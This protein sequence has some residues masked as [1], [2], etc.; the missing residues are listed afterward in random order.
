MSNNK[1]LLT[2]S[3]LVIVVLALLFVGVKSLTSETNSRTSTVRALNTSGLSD[4]LGSDYI[5]YSRYTDSQRNR[6]N[7]YSKQVNEESEVR[8]IGAQD[9]TEFEAHISDKLRLNGWVSELGS[10]TTQYFTSYKGNTGTVLAQADVK[11][12]VNDNNTGEAIPGIVNIQIRNNVPGNNSGFFQ[13]TRIP[14]SNELKVKLEKAVS[15]KFILIFITSYH[16]FES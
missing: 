15:E 5:E 14:Y 10:S 6:S 13:N 12:N 9:I 1:L 4:I 7:F 11:R 3:T 2:A 8:I 16:Q